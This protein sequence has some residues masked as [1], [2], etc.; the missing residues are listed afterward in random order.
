MPFSEVS[1]GNSNARCSAYFSRMNLILLFPDDFVDDTSHVRLQGRRLRHVLAVHRA[2]I[3]D[4]LCVGLSGG[5][6]GSGHVT[7]LNET[8]LEMEVRLNR[9]PPPALPVTLV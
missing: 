4:E 8:V 3:N 5:Q 9:K 2:S 7:S 1:N 6:V